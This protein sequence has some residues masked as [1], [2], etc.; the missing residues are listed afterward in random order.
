MT[1]INDHLCAGCVNEDMRSFAN[2][3][4]RS[5]GYVDAVCFL[6]PKMARENQFLCQ[7]HCLFLEILRSDYMIC[8]GMSKLLLG[9]SL[10][11]LQFGLNGGFQ[12]FKIEYFNSA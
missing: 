7:S 11:N 6:S 10:I 1:H 4:T 2:K 5:T 9:V 3:V 12:P 8:S